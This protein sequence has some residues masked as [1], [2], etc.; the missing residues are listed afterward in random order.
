[1]DIMRSQQDTRFGNNRIYTVRQIKTNSKHRHML[2]NLYIG[3][4]LT[5]QIVYA[6]FRLVVL[7]GISFKTVV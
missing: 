3:V 4:S 1:M 6:Q 2:L 7:K 5:D